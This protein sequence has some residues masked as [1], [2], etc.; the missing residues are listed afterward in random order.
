MKALTIMFFAG[1]ISLLCVSNSQSEDNF[2]QQ[3]SDSITVVGLSAIK[4]TQIAYNEAK[5][6]LLDSL[7]TMGNNSSVSNA[8]VVT[9]PYPVYKM[10]PVYVNTEKPCKEKIYV[11]TI[12][13]ARG[14]HVR[15]DSMDASTYEILTHHNH[16]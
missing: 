3:T 1:V 4:H 5:G 14:A 2:N 15:C 6:I 9:V 11:Y 10:Q 8:K 7:H 12:F 13:S 16:N